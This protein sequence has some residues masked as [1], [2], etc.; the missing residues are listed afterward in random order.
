MASVLSIPTKAF[1]LLRERGLRGVLARMCGWLWYTKKNVIFRLSPAAADGEPTFDDVRFRLARPDDCA[2]IVERMGHLGDK[3]ERLTAEQFDEGA[4][5]VLGVPADDPDKLAFTVW[6][7][8]NDVGLSLLGGAASEGDLSFR[9]A[10]VP[11]ERRRRGFAHK[12]M[13]YGACAAAARGAKTIWSFV[14]VENIAS[15]RMHE[16]L[17]YERFGRLDLITRFGRRWARL[18]RD[19]GGDSVYTRIPWDFKL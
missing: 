12:G 11:P 4:L 7:T 6:A 17:G 15:V 18:R 8:P 16:K 2:W 3:A 1:R 13:S 5:T 14:G 10:W 9:R 19:D